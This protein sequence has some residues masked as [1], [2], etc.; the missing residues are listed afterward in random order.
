MRRATTLLNIIRDRGNHGLP[1]KDAY[2]MLFQ[3][4]LYLMAYAKLYSNAGALTGSSP[5]LVVDTL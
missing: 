1:I 5:L 2:R 4:Q 3:K